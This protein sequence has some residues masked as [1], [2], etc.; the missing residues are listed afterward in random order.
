MPIESKLGKFIFG[1]F[2]KKLILVI[3][4]MQNLFALDSVSSIPKEQKKVLS[5]IVESLKMPSNS[6]SRNMIYEYIGFSL[7]NGWSAHWTTN[8][9]GEN[10]KITNNNVQIC[11]VTIY[12]NNHVVNATFVHFKKKKQLFITT[13]EYIEGESSVILKRYKEKKSDSK[14][15]IQNETDNYAYFQRDGYMEYETYHIKSPIGM[16]IYESSFILD[17]KE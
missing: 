5:Q 10:S 9:T 2:M 3:F 8:S 11:D 12:N 1:V 17:I 4:L 15:S 13:K 6:I 7:K 16:V 14:Y